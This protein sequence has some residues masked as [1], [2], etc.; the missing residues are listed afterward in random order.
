MRESQ[1]KSDE[2][3]M[4]VTGKATVRFAR[5]GPVLLVPV[6]IT[7]NQHKDTLDGLTQRRKFFQM[8]M[9]RNLEREV[10]RELQPI[11][12]LGTDFSVKISIFCKIAR[13]SCEKVIKEHDQTLVVDFNEDTKFSR[14]VTA[15]VAMKAQALRGKN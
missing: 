4:Q 13:Q 12:K 6:R 5:R 15:G 8:G 1:N 3:Y 7:V 14:L 2:W 9:L 10:E 11:D